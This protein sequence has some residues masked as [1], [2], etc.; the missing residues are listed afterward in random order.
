MI[1]EGMV[2]RI[3]GT[4]ICLEAV[5]LMAVALF[6]FHD[7]NTAVGAGYYLFLKTGK[8]SRQIWDIMVDFLLLIF[9]FLAVLIPYVCLKYRV[10]E[11]ALL[12]ISGVALNTYIR[13]DSLIHAVFE[14]AK[15]PYET[16]IS[17]IRDFLITWL[18]ILAVCLILRC[19]TEQSGAEKKKGNILFCLSVMLFGAAILSSPVSEILLWISGYL[20]LAAVV[21]LISKN[22]DRTQA[23]FATV[24]FIRGMWRLFFVLSTYHL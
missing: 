6:S 14:G 5:F 22:D 11:G 12:L 13:P 8:L 10:K 3:I 9:I 1:N 21:Y 19:F 18:I 15:K 16:F 2:K 23:V 7:V 20:L 4:V 24:L 17:D